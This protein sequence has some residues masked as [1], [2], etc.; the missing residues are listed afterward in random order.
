M[1]FTQRAQNGG[2]DMPGYRTGL[3]VRDITPP[4]EWLNA[5]P[6]PIWLWGFGNR[7]AACSQPPARD[8]QRLT[9]SALAISDE[10]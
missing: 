5:N 7:F 9:A 6:S 2:L 10:F 8:D 4:D 3:A 1:I